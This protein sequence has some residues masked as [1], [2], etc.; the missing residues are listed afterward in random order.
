MKWVSFGMVFGIGLNSR[1]NEQKATWNVQLVWQTIC[2]KK[3]WTYA[4]RVNRQRPVPANKPCHSLPT[5]VELSAERW[6]LQEAGTSDPMQALVE[7]STKSKTLEAAR[8][9]D[10]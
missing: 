10:N 5:L 3:N 6:T 8:P 7:L 4:V 9:S 1:E 2:K